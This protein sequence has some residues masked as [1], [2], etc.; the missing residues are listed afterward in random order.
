MPLLGLGVGPPI[1]LIHIRL[2]RNARDMLCWHEC[3][4]R[5]SVAGCLLLRRQ[6][7]TER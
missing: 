1:P 6:S 5:W 7:R 4:H 2:L 3:C